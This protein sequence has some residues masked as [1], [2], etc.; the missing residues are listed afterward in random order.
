[1]SPQRSRA[2]LSSLAS[3]PAPAFGL[4]LR[5]EKEEPRGYSISVQG[6]FSWKHTSNHFLGLSRSLSSSSAAKPSSGGFAR[7][8]SAVEHQQQASGCTLQAPVLVDRGFGNH[9]LSRWGVMQDH[10]HEELLRGRQPEPGR[11]RR[12]SRASGCRLRE[13][14]VRLAVQAAAVVVVVI[15]AAARGRFGGG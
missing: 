12:A 9:R 5:C 6:S 11:W 4:L 15:Q 2:S 7:G 8:V 10:I 1:M 13:W 3:A 14:L